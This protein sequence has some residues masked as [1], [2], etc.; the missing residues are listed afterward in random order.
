MVRSFTVAL[1]VVGSVFAAVGAWNLYQRQTTGRIAR[2]SERL[3]ET[4]ERAAV[5]ISG[6]PFFLGYDAP[7]TLPFLRRNEVAVEVEATN[8]L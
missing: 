3:L 1:G 4:L 7:W 5:P 8:R 6:N 2:E